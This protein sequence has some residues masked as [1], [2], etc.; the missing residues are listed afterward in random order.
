MTRTVC[1]FSSVFGGDPANLDRADRGAEAF[2]RAHPELL[3]ICPWTLWAR[4]GAH[5]HDTEAVE[6]CCAFIRERCDALATTARSRKYMSDGMVREYD[7]AEA[8]GLV[9]YLGAGE[10]TE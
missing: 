7:A 6:D 9:V 3:V 4:A 8:A 10:E 1:W 2:Q 5:G